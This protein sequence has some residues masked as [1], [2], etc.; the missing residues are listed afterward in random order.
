[1]RIWKWFSPQITTFWPKCRWRML[2]KKLQKRFTDG[3][4]DLCDFCDLNDNITW[5]LSVTG[6]AV[7]AIWQNV[8]HWRRL[9]HHW[10]WKNV[11]LN[12][13]NEAIKLGE[14]MCRFEQSLLS[15]ASVLANKMFSSEEKVIAKMMENLQFVPIRP[16][17]PYLS[18][19]C[20]Y[21]NLQQRRK[22]SLIEY[23]SRSK[24]L[25]PSKGQSFL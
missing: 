11:I 15:Q 12:D 19:V 9:W 10:W 24:I 8:I 1:M 6:I 17:G 2:T 13:H 4:V 25:L 5:L 7:L 18:P 22:K 16:S 21:E 20:N 3:S 14:E 23:S